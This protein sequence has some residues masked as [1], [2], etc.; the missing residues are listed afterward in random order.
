MNGGLLLSVEF[1][2][3]TFEGIFVFTFS[4]TSL[5]TLIFPRDSSDL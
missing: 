4:S 2:I 1:A 5:E 3:T